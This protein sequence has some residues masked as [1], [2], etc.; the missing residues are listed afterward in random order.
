MTA[1]MSVLR[2]AVLAAF[3]L[4]AMPACYPR[5]PAGL[6]CD[7]G[8]CPA[9]QRCNANGICESDDISIDAAIDAEPDAPPDAGFH[10]GTGLMQVD[11]PALPT[12]NIALSAATLNTDTSP[13]CAAVISSNGNYCVVAAARIA[14]TAKLRAF[15]ARPLV[16]LATDTITTNA[17]IDVGSH[18]GEVP[19]VGAGA[20]DRSCSAGTLPISAGTGGGAGGTF[21]T[22]GGNGGDGPMGGGVSPAGVSATT[23]TV[24][25]GGCAGQVGAGPL[26]G[27]GGSGGGAVF[28]FAGTSISIGGIVLAG[29]SGGGGGGRGAMPSGGG[30]GGS[31]GMIGFEAPMVTI[32]DPLVASGGGGGEGS[33][34]LIAGAAGASSSSTTDAPGGAGSSED[35]GDGGNGS[36]AISSA[37]PLQGSDVA[38][39][40]VAGGGGGGGG[41]GL[42]KIPAHATYT[43]PTPPPRTSPPPTP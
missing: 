5:L 26:K 27:S 12:G 28:L 41:A 9:G 23:I 15:G 7:E 6:A 20:N 21:L 33:D 32:G 16:L 22:R 40:L 29:G 1:S 25:R 34:P 35:G 3:A 30:G 2:R 19:E 18:R 17:P 13:L 38:M 36:R 43:L 8:Q 42:I 10:F 39:G 31:G 11:L 4:L 24:L 14:I 37:L